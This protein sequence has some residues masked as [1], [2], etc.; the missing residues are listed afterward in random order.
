MQPQG[1]GRQEKRRF[2]PIL[3]GLKIQDG[4]RTDYLNPFSYKLWL[5]IAK[6]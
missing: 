1:G 3:S 5:T 6:Y 2:P 4:G